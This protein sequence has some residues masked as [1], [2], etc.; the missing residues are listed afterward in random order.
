MDLFRGVMITIVTLVVITG[1]AVADDGDNTTEIAG[2]E[3]LYSALKAQFDINEFA[4]SREARENLRALERYLDRGCQYTHGSDNE[5]AAGMLVT[6]LED[7]FQVLEE[8][9]KRGSAFIERVYETLRSDEDR[10]N[11]VSLYLK[12]ENDIRYATTQ[13]DL[14]IIK[15]ENAN[16][17]WRMLCS[18]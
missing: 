4:L 2:S 13:L 5:V 10:L 9:K 3:G 15:A 12:M 16:R 11:L 18:R 6:Q 1:G 17:L 14:F 8:K 7:Y